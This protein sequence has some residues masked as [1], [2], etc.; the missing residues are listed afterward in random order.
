M[1]DISTTIAGVKFRNP[2]MTASG[3]YGYGQEFLDFFHPSELGAVMVKGTTLEP[4]KGNAAP[5]VIET[6][7]GMIN[8]VGLQNDGLDVLCSKHLPWL[9]K[10]KVGVIVNFSGNTVEE[11]CTLAERLNDE[12]GIKMLEV[13]ISC[14]NVKKGGLAFGAD[15][16]VASELVK[17]IKKVSKYP[18]IIKL[19]PN[20]TDIVSIAKAVEDA[21]A[22]SLSLINT[23]LGMRINIKNRKPYIANKMGGLSGP[24]IKPVAVRMVYQVSKAVDIPVIGMGGISSGE[25]AVEILIAGAKAISIG[26]ANFVDPYCPLKV[27]D[28]IEQYMKANG[29]QSIDELSGS[30]ID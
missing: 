10:N 15:K 18:L 8:A 25:D 16:D 3:T 7:A 5:R 29:F 14:P 12:A 27:I 28:Y 2:V 17:E 6:P 19:S 26:T 20:V 1:V 11:Y 23:L 13:N 9:R 30:I 4:K 22:D 24:A 21:G